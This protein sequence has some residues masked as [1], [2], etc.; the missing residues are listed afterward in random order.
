MSDEEEKPEI[1]DVED[2]SVPKS[3]ESEVLEFEF[4]EDG[5]EDLKKTLKKFRADLKV[6]KKENSELNATSIEYLTGWQ[7]ERAEFSNYKKQEDDRKTMF[8]ESMRERILTRF[9]TVMDSFNMAFANKESWEKVDENWRKGVEYIYTQ[10][11]TVFEEYG[12]KSIGEEGEIFDPNIH[13]SIE[14]VETDKK[15]LDHTVSSVTQKGYKLGERVMRPARVN[16]YEYK[17]ISDKV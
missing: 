6:C 2:N 14:V 17:E 10:F 7:K 12:V 4:N 16:V 9:L 13:Q 5:E 15:E 11:N 1:L 3:D 8:S